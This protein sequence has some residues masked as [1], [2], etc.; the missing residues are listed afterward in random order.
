M[1]M[2]VKLTARFTH[3]FVFVTVDS[4]MLLSSQLGSLKQYRMEVN[5]RWQGDAHT[6]PTRTPT[7]ARTLTG[8]Y[9]QV[10]K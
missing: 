10:C 3:C 2:F 7:Q 5:Y 8:A 1:G 4:T 9:M 6:D